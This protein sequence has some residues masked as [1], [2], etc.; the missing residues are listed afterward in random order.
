MKFFHRTFEE[1]WENR[2]FDTHTDRIKMLVRLRNKLIN[3]VTGEMPLHVIVYRVSPPNDDDE[4]TRC[5]ML[6]PQITSWC[7][8]N[9]I[10]FYHHGLN[11]WF[12]YS[13]EDIVMFKLRWF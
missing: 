10:Y 1:W 8:E 2:N 12:L 7:E 3:P 11:V 9:N 6:E 5:E 13:D 4:F